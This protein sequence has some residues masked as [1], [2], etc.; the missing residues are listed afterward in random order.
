MS[1][2]KILII[3]DEQSYVEV[4]KER[5]EFE[6]F[7]VMVALDGKTGLKLLAKNKYEAVLL[8]VMMP[9]FDGFEVKQY[10]NEKNGFLSHSP[11]IFVSAYGRSLSEEQKQIVG[12]SPFIRKP[13]EV[14][15]LIKLINEQK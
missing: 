12:K 3:D 15:D 13:F 10:I 4:L 8:D 11:I 5:L 6:R 14:K 2:K 1:K 9:G 7:E